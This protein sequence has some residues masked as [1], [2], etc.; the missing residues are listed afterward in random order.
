MEDTLPEAPPEMHQLDWF[1]GRWDV[2][3]RSKDAAGD[4]V[5]ESMGTNHSLI[6]GG[7]AILEHFRGPLMGQ[8]F[9]AWSLRK[10][11]PVG[12]RWEQRWVDTTP[13]G[14]ADWTGSWDES[15]RRFIGNP[16]RVLA[17]DGTL[18]TAAVREVFFEIEDDR[19]SWKYETTEDGGTIWAPSWELEYRRSSA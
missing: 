4:S 8:P 10:Y 15:S 18:A 1:L 12:E 14:F 16:N 13:G 5:E 19:F 3:S 7:H 2:I 9:E 17:A 6:L 11:N